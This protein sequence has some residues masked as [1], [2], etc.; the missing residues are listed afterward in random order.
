MPTNP[1]F[2]FSADPLPAG[3]FL[4]IMNTQT[5]GLFQYTM[6]EWAAELGLTCIVE[7]DV[8]E[9]QTCGGAL[10]DGTTV[11]VTVDE[12]ALYSDHP[13]FTI[14]F[15][16]PSRGQIGSSTRTLTSAPVGRHCRLPPINNAVSSTNA[17]AAGP[18]NRCS[19]NA[20][21]TWR[22]PA[23]TRTLM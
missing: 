10:A 23:A 15:I 19:V 16:A 21:T 18:G 11:S 22:T 20:A 9:I 7:L 1:E 6:D 3:Q 5:P 12:E 13:E 14:M 2:Y 17:R 8:Y 4:V